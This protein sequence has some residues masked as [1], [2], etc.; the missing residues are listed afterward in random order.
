ML[1]NPQLFEDGLCVWNSRL[2]DH[3]LITIKEYVSLNTYIALNRPTDPVGGFYWDHAY[4]WSEGEIEP[5]I[6]WI[7]YHISIN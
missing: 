2:H 4:Y 3:N 7:K 6:E 1:D 5:R